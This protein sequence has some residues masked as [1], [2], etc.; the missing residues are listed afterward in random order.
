MFDALLVYEDMIYDKREIIKLMSE[1]GVK[2]RSKDF[3]FWRSIDEIKK[4][5][6]CKRK[7]LKNEYKDKWGFGNIKEIDSIKKKHAFKC[8]RE[9]DEEKI[10]R[11]CPKVKNFMDKYYSKKIPKLEKYSIE[12]YD[13]AKKAINRL[14]V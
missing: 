7:W 8:H 11:L 4:F 3:G 14:Y 1:S 9:K 10:N 2:V 5:N 12:I 6:F 13:C